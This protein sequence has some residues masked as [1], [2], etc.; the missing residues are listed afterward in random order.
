MKLMKCLF[1]IILGVF[2]ISACGSSDDD[3]ENTGELILTP[4][5][6]TVTVKREVVFTVTEGTADVT[7]ECK[8]WNQTDA[9]VLE[10][11]TFIPEKAGI[12]RFVAKRGNVVSKEILITV[13]TVDYFVKNMLCLHFTACGCSSCPAGMNNWKIITAG[14][15]DYIHLVSIHGYMAGLSDPFMVK[16]YYSPLGGAYGVSGYPCFVLDGAE[17]MVWNSQ[18]TAAYLLNKYL[19]KPGYLGI[20]L[21]TKVDGKTISVDV[22]AR[23]FENLPEGCR[24]AVVLTQNSLYADQQNGGVVEKNY[25]HSNVVRKYLTDLFGDRVKT[26]E[27]GEEVEFS[28]SFTYTMTDEEYSSADATKKWVPS[29]MDVTVYFLNQDKTVINSQRVELGRSRDYEYVK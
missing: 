20:A 15:E 8:I 22:K 4:N 7:Q 23:S 19:A 11:N 25:M 24:I 17:Q 12:Y 13:T 26:E 14:Q 1:G 6:G 9:K 29:T 16:E 18:Q 28:R 21:D 10:G 3:V 5:R 2:F 27:L